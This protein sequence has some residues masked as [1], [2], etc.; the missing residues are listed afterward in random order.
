MRKCLLPILLLLPPLASAGSLRCGPYVIESSE[1]QARV[2]E[3][4][5]EP[6][7][8]WQDGYFEEEYG[9]WV[10]SDGAVFSEPGGVVIYPAQSGYSNRYK[11]IIPIYRWEYRPGRG[12]FIKTLTFYGDRLFS[13][14]DGPRQ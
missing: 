10:G 14:E 3:L 9:G 5:G 1:S 2:L 12:R 4:C 7:R 8:A 11:R 6:Y 13:I